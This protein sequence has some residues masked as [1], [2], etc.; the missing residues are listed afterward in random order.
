MKHE[1]SSS[2]ALLEL[3]TGPAGRDTDSL[4]ADARRDD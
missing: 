3:Q 2:S 1:A 4:L